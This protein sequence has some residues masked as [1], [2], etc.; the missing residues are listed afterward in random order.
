MDR[1]GAAGSDV[2]PA[3]VFAEAARLRCGARY[4]GVRRRCINCTSRTS[5]A[6]GAERDGNGRRPPARGARDFEHRVDTVGGGDSLERWSRALTVRAVGPPRRELVTGTTVRHLTVRGACDFE[7]ESTAPTLSGTHESYS[8]T[9]VRGGDA[10]E[11]SYSGRASITR[12]APRRLRA[13]RV[14][15]IDENLAAQTLNHGLRCRKPE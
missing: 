13:L 3:V 6:T 9:G 10:I 14:C 8:R 4:K 1:G 5:I 2:Y 12:V 15:T 11:C 7:K